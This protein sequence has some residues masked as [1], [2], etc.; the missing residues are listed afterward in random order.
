MPPRS[1]V[2]TGGSSG[3]G[4]ALAHRFAGPGVAIGLIARGAEALAAAA[5]ECAARGARVAVAPA[6]V[7][8][9][10]AL[11]EAAGRL[12]TAL[13]PPDL[14]VNAAGNGTFAR[15]TETPEAEF[16]RV[17]EVTFQGTVHGTR[18]ALR[19]MG[20]EGGTV[21]N[22]CSAVAFRGLPALAAYSAAKAAVQSFSRVVRAELAQDRVPVRLLLL[23][24]PAVNTPFFAHSPCHFAGS[25]RPAPPVYQ[26]EPVARAMHRAILRGREEARIGAITVVF[27]AAVRAVPGVIDW[28]IGRLGYEGQLTDCPRAKAVH[29][30]TLFGP[31]QVGEGGVRGTFGG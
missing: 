16:R 18:E 2:I 23:Y 7:A 12:Q 10:A 15:F 30:P 20:P 31:G 19:R 22:V 27:D 13:G 26:P 4:R 3:L 8:D 11:S 14:W 24:P 28:C 17:M 21:A 29:A 5:A 9:A 25:P 6:D 1:I